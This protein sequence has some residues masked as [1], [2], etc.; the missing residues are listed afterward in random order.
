MLNPEIANTIKTGSFNTNYHDLGKGDSIIFIHG[1]GPGVSAF[2][3]W[4]GTMPVIADNF[5]V[6]AP[7]MVGFG[8]TDRPDGIKYNMDI[9]IKQIID[10]MDSLGIQKTNLVGNSFGGAL[11]IA[12]TIRYPKR[13]N[14][15]VLMGSV[16][17]YFDL[18]Y[19]LDK[20]WGY[21]PSIENM[22]ELL[23]IFAYDRS[24]VTDDLAKLR[25]EASIRS[26]F[27]E[28]FSSMFPAPRQEGVDMMTSCENDIKKINKEVLIIHG[29]E[30]KVIPVQNSIKLNQLISKSQLHVFGEC[31]HWTQ[32]EHKDRFNNLLLNFFS[33]K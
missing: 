8:Y 24:I 26:G 9:W 25:Y 5:R 30:D 7:D 19:G 18:T 28:S 15:I 12:L 20:A 6:I 14:K 29:R 1:S 3:N 27:Q 22:K 17:V 4:R 33:E 10:L 21:T 16:G 13:F 11:A 32:I 31:G 23:D 2:A